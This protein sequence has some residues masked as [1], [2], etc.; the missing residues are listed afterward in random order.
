MEQALR[1]RSRSRRSK[2]RYGADA[3]RRLPRAC[4]RGIRKSFGVVPGAEGRRPRD[5]RRASSSA[6]SARRAAARRR[7]CA[8]SPGSRR[9]PPAA[10][11]RAAATSRCCRRPSATTASS[12]SRTRSFPNLTIA[13]NVAYGLVN[14]KVARRDGRGARRRAADAGRPARQRRQVP[15]AALGRPAAAH[16]AGARAGHLAAACCCSTSRCRR[17]TRSSACACAARS[18]RCSEQLGVTTIMVTHDQEE[19]LSVAD[20]IVV[21]NHGAIEQV[22]TPLQVYREPATP[23][24]ADFVGKIN[25]LSGR[26]LS[27]RRAAHRR[28]PLRSRSTTTAAERDV[29]I[30][31]RPEDVLARPIAPGDANVFDGADREDRVPRLVLPR[32]RQRRGDRAGAVDGLPVAQLPRRAGARGRQPPAAQAPAASGCASSSGRR[33][34]GRSP[35]PL[36]RRRAALR[37]RA[38]WSDRVAHVGAAGDRRS[39]WSPS[40]PC[41]WRRSS[42][43]RCRTTTAPSSAWP[44]SRATSRTPALLQSFVNSVWVAVA[45]HARHRAARLR[46]R[47]RAGAQLH[48][49]QG[50]VPHH[51]ADPAARAVAAVG[52]L[53]H[54]LVR[55]PGRRQAAGH[56]ARLREHLRRARHRR[57]RVLRRL[58]ARADDPAE[59][60]R[61]RR[62]APLRSGRRAR[63]LDPAQVLRRSRC[64]APSTA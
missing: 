27:A 33:R 17:S 22:G 29:K 55:Q 10:S 28:A 37:L 59:R 15:G 21:M 2:R 4:D 24:V 35:L 19:A 30:Y 14:R 8:S 25:V 3:A 64:P 62:R 18:A 44:T 42:P 61:A 40:S 45:G 58:P 11:S 54:L 52:D 6:S 41:R 31:L 5:R 57:R 49:R 48:P 60:A 43:R 34:H 7:C 38:H 47:L 32:A 26:L 51:R 46:L 50:P 56:G 20:R 23:F 9:R 1:R 12:S 53:A 36:P 13:D 39:R 16:R 63:H